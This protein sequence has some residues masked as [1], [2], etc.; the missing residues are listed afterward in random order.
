MKTSPSFDF[1]SAFAVLAGAFALLAGS[2]AHAQSVFSVGLNTSALIGHPA[3]PF[4]LDFQLNDGTGLGNGNNTAI[5]SQFNF[6][7][8]SFLGP[9]TSFGGVTGSLASTVTLTDTSAFNEFFQAFTPGSF[10]NFR[11]SLTT[12]FNAP[13]PDLFSLSILDGDLFNVRTFSPGN[14]DALVIVNLTGPNSIV[15]TYAGSGV[16]DQ[17]GATTIAFAAPSVTPVPEPSAY[18]LLGAALVGAL[19]WA[20]RHPKSARGNAL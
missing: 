12:N 14:S 8:G 13:T 4:Y 19:A 9:A 1:R 6:N 11:L 10:L 2:P 3:G 7:G 16:P 17:T 15:N 18:G 20:R 5:L